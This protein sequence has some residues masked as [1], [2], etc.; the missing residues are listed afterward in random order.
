MNKRS[1]GKFT[2]DDGDVEVGEPE[3]D[4]EVLADDESVSLVQTEEE[5]RLYDQG[6]KDKAR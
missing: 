4:V 6:K 5:G 1:E 3:G 2:W